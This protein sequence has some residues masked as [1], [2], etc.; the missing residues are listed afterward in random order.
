MGATLFDKPQSRA[1]VAARDYQIEDHDESFRLWDSGICGTLTR[2]ATGTGKTIMAC[3]KM[4]TWLKRGPDYRCLVLS[5]EKQLVWQF[6]QE[7]EDVLGIKPGIEMEKESVHPDRIPLIV[8][9]SRQTLLPATHATKE[10]IDELAQ[11]GITNVGALTKKRAASY[12]RMLRKEQ[13]CDETIRD[14][15]WNLNRQP[16]AYGNQWSRLH[17]F[18][19]KKNWLVTMDEAHKF[20]HR[21]KSV[22]YLVDWFDQNP[23]SRRSGITA[24]PKRGDGVNIGHKMFPGVS[25]DFPLYSAVGRCAVKEG[26]AVPYVQK[27]I[28]VEGVDFKKLSKIAGDFDDEEL[29][30]V[31]G[32]EK[33]LAKLVAPILDMVGDRKTLIFVPGVDMAKNV[34]RFINARAEVRCPCGAVAWHPSLLIGDGAQ[35]ACGRMLE[36]P[37]ITKSGSQASF[38]VGSIPPWDRKQIYEGHKL[39]KFQFLVVCGLCREGYNDPDISCVAVLRPV[40]KAASSLAEQMKGRGCRPLRGLINGLD[41][42]QERLE[43]IANS[44]K[45]NCLI[46]DLVGITG[47]G[48]CASTVQIYADGLDDEV[49][50][51]AEELLSESEEPM[52]VEAAIQHAKEEIEAERER[53]RKEREEAERKAKEEFERRAKADAQVNYTAHEVGAGS[54]DPMMASTGQYK[55]LAFL[56]I[57]V[58]GIDLTKKQAGR[59]IDQLNAGMDAEDVAYNTGIRDENWRRVPASVPQMSLLAKMKIRCDDVRTKKQASVLIEAHKETQ[60]FVKQLAHRIAQARSD[61]ELTA[62]AKELALAK[63]VLPESEYSQLAKVGAERRAALRPRDEEEFI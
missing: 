28:S 19:W 37:D 46:I 22:G 31:L 11:F 58:F 48:D 20:A 61:R 16:E 44:N 5:Y 51:K 10:Q 60:K 39:G 32:E 1:N 53:I 8:V 34:C 27:Y 54:N 21:L 6:A 14:A 7:I 50:E 40:S 63:R 62:A 26:Y 45:P 4:D 35:C 38:V 43:A 9:A 3:L 2:S 57:E 25:L 59:M 52:E 42:A 41:T 33:T 36:V 15:I 49:A 24:T 13:C 18:D 30:R 56:G 12:L 29:E 55:L 17:K 47:L 23:H